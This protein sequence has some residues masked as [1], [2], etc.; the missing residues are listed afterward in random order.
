MK[1]PFKA[2]NPAVLLTV[3]VLALLIL[4]GPVQGF[5][6]NLSLDDS[7]PTEG[8]IIIFTAEIEIPSGERLPIDYLTLE[9]T[10]P[11]TASCQF[12]LD[13]TIISGCKGIS[14]VLNQNSNFGYGYNYGYFGYGYNFG[15]GYG[16][17]TGKL[18]YTITLDTSNYT[19]G[20]YATKLKAKI[21]D[22]EFSQQGEQFTLSQRS[23]GA[24]G[25][26]SGGR[27]CETE[28]EC[29]EWSVCVNGLQTRT[30]EKKINYCY[31]GE[32]PE[33]ERACNETFNPLTDTNQKNQDQDEPI[34]LD[35]ERET[36]EPFVSRITGAVTG[37]VGSLNSKEGIVIIFLI[38][39]I[40]VALGI[41]VWIRAMRY[42]GM[43]R[44]AES[45]Y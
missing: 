12:N 21:G 25:G 33:L 32:I 35:F 30:C 5:T 40:V 39:S 20:T 37:A 42:R 1:K 19:T 17:G 9:L 11:E 2:Q 6:L 8:D 22:N 31:A 43:R 4:A 18:I 24:G 44:S 41:V 3:L 26:T 45:F 28:W 34:N 14:I 16:Y 23:T 38:T 29:S 7:A 27:S 13:G 36:E 10:G 15:Y